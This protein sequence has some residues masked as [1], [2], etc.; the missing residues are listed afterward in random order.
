M[1]NCLALYP[2]LHAEKMKRRE[3]INYVGWTSLGIL[4]TIG[5]N[6]LLASC[7]S[8]EPAAK[9]SAASASDAPQKAVVPSQADQQ[10]ANKTV[11]IVNFKYQPA[12]LTVRVGETVKFV[13]QDD[14]PHTA[15]AKDVSFN[16]KAL[17]TN[18]S[19]TYK[20]T[21]PGTF[22][23]FCSIHPFMKGTITVM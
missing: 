3:C 1:E 15:T 4:W 8:T 22:P 13:N 2:F 18:E 19:W 23:Y 12:S 16:S 14:E 5:T 9:K 11:K 7:H 10:K 17:D 20:F 21:K 6:S